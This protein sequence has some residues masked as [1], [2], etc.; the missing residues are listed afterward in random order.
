[1]N[2]YFRTSLS[3]ICN[4]RITFK[5]NSFKFPRQIIIREINSKTMSTENKDTLFKD[6]DSW[7][8]KSVNMPYRLKSPYLGLFFRYKNAPDAPEGVF[9]GVLD[10][11]KGITVDSNMEECAEGQFESMLKDSLEFWTKENRRAIW[12]KVH[13]KDSFWVPVLAKV[14]KCK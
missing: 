12:F 10:R 2:K 1:M 3:L 13:L 11:F 5:S 9:R 14:T 4:K 6:S 8:N 7:F